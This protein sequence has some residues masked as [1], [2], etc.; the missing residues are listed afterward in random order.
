MLLSHFTPHQ[1]VERAPARRL[2]R[3][4]RVGAAGQRPQGGAG[5]TKDSNSARGACPNGPDGLGPAGGALAKHIDVADARGHLRR[6]D[7]GLGRRRR[8]F[9]AAERLFR[10]RGGVHARGR[11]RGRGL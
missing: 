10:A 2:G 8:V 6:V 3:R 9:W 1:C 4:D 11:G 7:R 5:I